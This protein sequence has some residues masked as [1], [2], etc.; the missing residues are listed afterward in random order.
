[1]PLN[2]VFYHK[3]RMIESIFLSIVRFFHFPTKKPAEKRQATEALLFFLTLMH[4][5]V[6]GFRTPGKRAGVPVFSKERAAAPGTR[7]ALVAPA[8]AKSL[9]LLLQ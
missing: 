4:P 8:D 9:I 2:R 5:K 3:T 7:K 1:M 6:Q